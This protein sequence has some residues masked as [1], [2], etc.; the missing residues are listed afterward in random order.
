[1]MKKSFDKVTSPHLFTPEI[2]NLNSDFE[3]LWKTNKPW[4]FSNLSHIAY[5][6][7]ENI[8]KYM[9]KLGNPKTFFYNHDGAQAF[10]SIWNDK[11]VLVFRGTQP[12]EFSDKKHQRL[13]LFHRIIIKLFIKLP[14]NPFSLLFLSNDVLAD[15]KFIHSSFEGYKNV[16]VHSGFLEET[17]KLWNNKT[18]DKN[19]LDDIKQ[20]AS[21]IPI[22]VTGHSLGGAMSTIAG[23]RY[24]FE[25]V[26]TFG[27]PRVGRKIDLAFQAK[28]HTRYVNGD[29]PVT[30][31]PP[32]YFSYYKHH[33]NRKHI[34]DKNGETDFVY[35]HSIIY[36]SENLI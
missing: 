11:A 15:F 30:K 18:P 22:W 21:S 26:I 25:E 34:T 7:K 24:P 17:N 14:I 32:K 5:F 9:S 27:E 28:V 33:G 1:M 20:Y 10:L 19:I 8:F 6:R 12:K 31:L 29:D 16:K 13:T 4:L 3:T 23:M 35:D 36:Y 2:I